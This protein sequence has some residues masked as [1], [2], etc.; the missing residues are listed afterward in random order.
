M[1]TIRLLFVLTLII[2]AISCTEK[3]IEETPE[4]ADTTSVVD[5]V[6]AAFAEKYPNATDVEWA[7]EEFGW[8]VEFKLDGVEYEAEYDENG[9][10]IKTEHEISESE[11]PDMIQNTLDGEYTAYAIMGVEKYDS[12]EGSYYEVKL[13]KGGD[14][15]E[16]KFYPNGK[17]IMPEENAKTGGKHSEMDND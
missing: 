11:L 12:R 6:K 5:N 14:I 8:E 3:K 10:W 9:D 13:R 17:I 4:T 7:Q 2:L 1:K 15:E 16:A